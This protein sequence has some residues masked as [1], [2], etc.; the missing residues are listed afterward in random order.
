MKIVDV[1]VTVKC[2]GC[3]KKRDIRAGEIPAGEQPMCDECGMPMIAEK[4][5][6]FHRG[7]AFQRT[8]RP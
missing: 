3:G 8:R 1:K 4:A 2:I 6:I 7:L 5:G